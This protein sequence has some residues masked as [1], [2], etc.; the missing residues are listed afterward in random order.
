MGD[1]DAPE[2]TLSEAIMDLSNLGR[3]VDGTGLA[4]RSLSCVSKRVSQ[5]KVV[6]AYSHLQ[7]I[8]LSENLVKDVAPLKGLQ[9]IVKLNLSKNAIASLKGWDSEEPILP[10]LTHLDLSDNQ[11]P[12]LGP[13]ALKALVS[14]SVARNEITTCENFGGHEK[15]ESLDLSSNKL[16][17]LAGLGAMPALKGLNASANELVDLNGISEATALEELLVSGNKMQAVEGPWAELQ[18][19]RSIDISSCLL[20]SE[21][22]LEALRQLPLLRSLKV[23]GNPFAAGDISAQVL[24]LVCHWRL[25]MVDDVPITED[26]VEQAKQLNQQRILEERARLKAEQEAAE[27]AE[28]EG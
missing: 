14:L 24:A 19:M 9:F 11:L 12:A 20:E 8:D 13:L 3:I 5:I 15:I 23:S 26:H 17:S 27:A 25:E 7:H 6:E 4:F 18:A 21:K 22:P 1:E 28:A 16:A 10:N 2:Q